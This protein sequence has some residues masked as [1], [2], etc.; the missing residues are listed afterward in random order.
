MSPGI[1]PEVQL[2]DNVYEVVIAAADLA[3][4]RDEIN[5]ALGYAGNRSDAYFDQCIDSI[6]PDLGDHITL[7]AGYKLVDLS[8]PPG[9]SNGIYVDDTLF[10][11]ER[12]I[13]GLLR[14]ADRAA[15]FLCS[16]GPEL[17]NRSRLLLQEGDPALSYIVNTVASRAVE[18]A[19][20]LL[21]DHI[22][23]K[24]QRDG[25]NITNRYSPGYCNWS[26]F[27]QHLLFSLLPDGFCGVQLLESALMIPIK[28]VSGIIGIGKNVKRVDYS[29]DRCKI[30]D[31][32]VRLEKPSGAG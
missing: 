11:L 4:G 32:T 15:L 20:D 22:G 9:A 18:K 25:L 6:L 31:C 1:Y 10:M 8:R 7:Q 30:P 13:T 2:E 26:V 23:Q 5:Q 19:T 24:M 29:C 27:E 14:K 16:I 17:E 12:V 3:I 21:H 28:S